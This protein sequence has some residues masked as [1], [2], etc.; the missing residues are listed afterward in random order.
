MTSLPKSVLELSKLS[1]AKIKLLRFGRIWHEHI[2]LGYRSNFF[3]RRQP[4]K[5]YRRKML[6]FCQENLLEKKQPKKITGMARKRNL[7]NSHLK[8]YLK[9]VTPSPPSPPINPSYSPGYIMTEI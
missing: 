6:Y 2:G 5:G 7:P 3:N 4:Q 9:F 1:I 8:R